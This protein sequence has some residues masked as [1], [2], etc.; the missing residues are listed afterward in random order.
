M[1]KAILALTMVVLVSAMAMAGGNKQVRINGFKM[2]YVESGPKAGEVII[3]LHGYTDS[4]HSWSSTAPLLADKYHTFVLDQRGFGDSQ[5][6][7]G[8]Y[9]IPQLAE[10]VV[11]FMDALKIRKAVLVGHS[12]GTFVAQQV[13]WVY[14]ERISKLVLVASGATMVRNAALT[15]VN[16]TVGAPDFQDPI[17]AEFIEAWQTGPNPVAPEFFARVLQETAKPPARVWKAALRGLL[18]DDHSAFLGEITAPTLIIW[19]DQDS[20]F[21]RADQD[22]LLAAIPAAVLKVYAGA[23]HNVQWEVGRN[24]QVA[25]DIRAFLER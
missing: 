24:E 16:K 9:T 12:M 15:D 10:D 5:R 17:S 6:P 18:T 20:I 1:K 4:S 13:G 2:R 11:A 8:G 23:G 14:P 3:F 19:G 22:A 7:Q 21:L 25:G